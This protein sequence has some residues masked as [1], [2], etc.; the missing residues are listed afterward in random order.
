MTAESSPSPEL[1]EC[2]SALQSIAAQFL[3]LINALIAVSINH[4]SVSSLREETNSLPV[5]VAEVLPLLLQAAGSS[6]NTLVQL[7]SKSGLHTRDCYSIA[8]SVVEVAT[9]ICYIM[10]EGPDAAE[11]AMRHARQKSFQDL[12]REAKIGGT[13]IRVT[14]QGRPDASSIPGL[15]ADI[16]EFTQKSGWEKSPWKDER[17]D[18]RIQVVGQKLNKNAS[19]NLLFARFMVYRH[20]SE[21]LHGTLFSALYFFGHTQPSGKS[22]SVQE[23]IEFI[24]EQHMLILFA[25]VLALSAIVEAFDS[26]YGFAAA[27]KQA[28]L[29]LDSMV[30]IPY[31]RKD[32]NG[33]SPE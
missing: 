24:G 26:A 21:V 5:A 9:N 6:S 33:S 14:Y 31:F 15:E 32:V 20:A 2:L 25:V 11:R 7:S 16:A 19:V 4:E 10:A 1:V 30:E 29:L 22:R 17:I 3:T 13:I 28:K 27:H 8:R 18:A 23:G 12:E